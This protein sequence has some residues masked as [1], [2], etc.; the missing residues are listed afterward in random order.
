MQPLRSIC[1]IQRVGW[2]LLLLGTLVASQAAAAAERVE[3]ALPGRTKLYSRAQATYVL[4]DFFRQHP[5]ERFTLGRTSKVAGSWIA[6]GVYW[7]RQ[8]EDP[9]QVYLRLR[10]KDRRWVL[11]EIRIEQR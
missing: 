4:E 9:F 11:R 2:C 6:A 5:P 3:L 1:D 10:Q 7:Y 8:G